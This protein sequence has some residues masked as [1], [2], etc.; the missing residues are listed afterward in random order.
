MNKNNYVRVS[1]L[2][3]QW[4]YWW[5]PGK[6]FRTAKEIT[7]KAFVVLLTLFFP[8]MPTLRLVL[9]PKQRAHHRKRLKIKRRGC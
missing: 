8:V 4:R 1:L 5:V 6:D 9:I 2:A 3:V 7:M